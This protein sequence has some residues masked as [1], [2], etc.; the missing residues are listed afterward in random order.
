MSAKLKIKHR[1]SHNLK[2]VSRIP[3]YPTKK[4][5]LLFIKRMTASRFLTMVNYSNEAVFRIRMQSN[6]V[7]QPIQL[8]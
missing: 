1:L 6:S 7:S 2:K 8:Y 5:V 4:T 3:N